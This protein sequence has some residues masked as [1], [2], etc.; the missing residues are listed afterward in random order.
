MANIISSDI[1]SSDCACDIPKQYAGALRDIHVKKENQENR[2]TGGKEFLD[3][4][5][6]IQTSNEGEYD[7]NMNEN[8]M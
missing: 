7:E 8:I 1:V 2:V 4:N 5:R 3:I 6:S